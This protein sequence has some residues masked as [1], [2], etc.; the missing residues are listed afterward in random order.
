M[1]KEK[2]NFIDFILAAQQKEGLLKGFA[3][4]KTLKKLTE[5]FE[6]EGYEITKKDC[7]KLIKAKKEI[8]MTEWPIPPKY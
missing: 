8:G 7:K 5:F 4:A 3:K 6:K 1:A 2:K